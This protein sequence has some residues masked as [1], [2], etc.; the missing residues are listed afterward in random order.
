MPLLTIAAY[1]THSLQK[2]MQ[3]PK[4]PLI[5][6]VLV[7]SEDEDL[8]DDIQQSFGICMAETAVK[9][10][11]PEKDISQFLHCLKPQL[12][13]LDLNGGNDDCFDMLK[14]IK[15]S[16]DIPVITMS[17]L[18]DETTLVKSLEYGSDG[19]INKP[20][21]QLEFIAH[22]RAVIRRASQSYSHKE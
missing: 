16:S 17:Y 15:T 18:R 3:I 1:I 19:H 9:I 5:E 8:V 22:V 13:I 2:T 14:Q 20:I 7:A 21:R 6:T 10:I 4:Q 12:V 11:S